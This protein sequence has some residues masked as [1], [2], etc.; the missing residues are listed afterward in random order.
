MFVP[1]NRNDLVSPYWV[2]S[3]ADAMSRD[4]AMASRTFYLDDK[5][6]IWLKWIYLLSGRNP[7]SKSSSFCFFYLDNKHHLISSD[8]KNLNWIIHM[9]PYLRLLEATGYAIRLMASLGHYSG[10][11]RLTWPAQTHSNQR[12]YPLNRYSVLSL[13]DLP[14]QNITNVCSLH[15]VWNSQSYPIVGT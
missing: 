4:I 3:L 13:S 6:I 9:S 14:N 10:F 7:I 11:I 8:N 15:N 1:R 5:C 2:I 12:S